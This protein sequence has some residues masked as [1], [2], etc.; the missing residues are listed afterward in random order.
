MP[1]A[2]T[3]SCGRPE[4]SFRQF[5]A[6]GNTQEPRTRGDV[7]AAALRPSVRAP[8]QDRPGGCGGV[9]GCGARRP[10]SCR[11]GQ[12][13]GTTGAGWRGESGS[14]AFVNDAHG[15]HQYACECPPREHGVH[16]PAG[17]R[18]GLRCRRFPNLTIRRTSATR[19]VSPGSVSPRPS[20]KRS[21]H[22]RRGSPE[23]ARQL[24]GPVARGE[25]RQRAIR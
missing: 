16:L 13:R 1:P 3:T 20:L 22:W 25:R 14:R 10:D 6:L 15:A 24:H 17:E 21:G 11:A 23:V 2:T 12:A 4:S 18:P 9:G 5:L 8:E 7:V 19:N